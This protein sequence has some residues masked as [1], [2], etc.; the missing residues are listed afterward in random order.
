MLSVVIAGVVLFCASVGGLWLA[1]ISPSYQD[2]DAYYKQGSAYE[3]SPNSQK[4]RVRRFVRCEGKFFDANKEAIAAGATTVIAWFTLAL[5]LAT[6]RQAQLTRIAVEAAKTSADAL[7]NIERAYL[8]MVLSD[9]VCD[10]SAP[11]GDGTKF[12]HAGR[13]YARYYFVNHGK[14]PAIIHEIRVGTRLSGEPLG[15]LSGPKPPTSLSE[16]TP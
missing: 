3:E 6:R 10:A 13:F 8:F 9:W 7:P 16:I 12:L 4:E 5:W 15:P 2:C 1:K 14:T 11:Y